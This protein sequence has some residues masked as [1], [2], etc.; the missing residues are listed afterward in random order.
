MLRSDHRGL[1]NRDL[2]LMWWGVY[3]AKAITSLALVNFQYYPTITPGK[4]PSTLTELKLSQ[5]RPKMSKTRILFYT[6]TEHGIASHPS[7]ILYCEFDS[8]DIVT[9]ILT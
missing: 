1:R 6:Y 5:T 8:A 4:Q 3:R 7:H 2:K 9:Y